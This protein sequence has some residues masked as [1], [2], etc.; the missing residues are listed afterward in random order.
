[1]PTGKQKQETAHPK[2]PGQL[3]I[4]FIEKNAEHNI[5]NMGWIARNLTGVHSFQDAQRK[6]YAPTKPQRVILDERIINT[7]NE[8]Y[9]NQAFLALDDQKAARLVTSHII[10]TIAKT[11]EHHQWNDRWVKELPRL[12]TILMTQDAQHLIQAQHNEARKAADF[13]KRQE[14]T[15]R[16][17]ETED[18][19]PP[20]NLPNKPGTNIRAGR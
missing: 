5:K 9:E 19:R 18:I 15:K 6:G 11:A 12:T 4:A 2:T 17:A 3:F 10:A 20:A 13:I 1:M 16:V 8:L 14:D 7:V